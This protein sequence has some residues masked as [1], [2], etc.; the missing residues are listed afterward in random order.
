M[1]KVAMVEG[2]ALKSRM[3]S[4]SGMQGLIRGRGQPPK[5]LVRRMETL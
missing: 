5:K 2:V 4:A 1:T 3:S